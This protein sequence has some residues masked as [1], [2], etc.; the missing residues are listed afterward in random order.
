[1]IESGV[2]TCIRSFVY[3]AVR[4]FGESAWLLNEQE[5]RNG[6]PRVI[7]QSDI[8]TMPALALWPWAAE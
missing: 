1:M 8:T 7:P 6:Q 4:S 5:R 2:G 3:Q